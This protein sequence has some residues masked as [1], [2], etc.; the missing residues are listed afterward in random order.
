MT[1]LYERNFRFQNKPSL[2]TCYSQE[3]KTETASIIT[4]SFVVLV[5]MM[6]HLFFA[7]LGI[8]QI[9]TYF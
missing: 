4:T 1:I 6:L 2:A 9:A 8:N 3:Q 7:Y 5:M